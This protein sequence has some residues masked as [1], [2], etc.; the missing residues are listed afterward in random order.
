M[1]RNYLITALRHF[2]RQ[3]IYSVVNVLGLAMSTAFCFLAFL[4]VQH[5]WS[6][7][8]FHKHA[9]QIYRLISFRKADTGDMHML[10]ILPENLGPLLKGEFPQLDRIVRIVK[11]E[12]VVI[13]TGERRYREDVLFVDEDFFEL[14]SFPL[15]QGNTETFR[16]DPQSLVLSESVA[17]NLFPGENPIGKEI[18]IASHHWKNEPKTLTVGGVALDPPS[19]SSIHFR[20]LLPYKLIPPRVSGM[21]DSPMNDPSKLNFFLPRDYIFVRLHARANLENIN[22]ALPAFTKT[23]RIPGREVLL[24]FQPLTDVHLDQRPTFLPLMPSGNPVYAYILSAIA[25]MV[26]LIAS[27]NFMNLATAR[28]STRAREVGIRKVVGAQRTHL[29]WQFWGES[30]VM[31]AIAMILGISLAE[32]CL[33]T[34][35]SLI[36]VRLLMTDMFTLSFVLFAFVLMVF[37]A[38]ISGLYP[39]VNLSGFQAVTVLKDKIRSGSSGP[40]LRALIIVQFVGSILLVT[41]TAV[42]FLQVSFIKTKDLGIDRDQIAVISTD[43]LLNQ[44]NMK[45]ENLRHLFETFQQQ[46]DSYSDILGVTRSDLFSDI[47]SDYQFSKL[48]VRSPEGDEFHIPYIDIEENFLQVL[49]IELLHGQP[50]SDHTIINSQHSVL[51]NETLVKQLG[52]SQPLGYQVPLTRRIAIRTDTNQIKFRIIRNPEIA[53]IVSDFHV[54]SLHQAVPPLIIFLRPE[55]QTGEFLVRIRSERMPETLDFMARQWK[56]VFGI[57]PFNYTFLNERFDHLYQQ[58]ERW[59][60]M[61]AY[62]S[63]FALVVACLGVFGLTAMAISM[64]T[65]EF[66]IRKVFGASTKHIVTLLSMDFILLITIAT[67]IAWPL[68]YY[69]ASQWLQNFAYRIN[70]GFEIFFFGGAMTIVI[71]LATILILTIKV[72]RCN[73][74]EILRYE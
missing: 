7:D 17:Q 57:T 42:M 28:F 44:S 55:V 2:T 48:S 60:L 33:P 69:V 39:A 25:G 16:T 67:L 32:L 24:Q 74:V 52:L 36:Q 29:M 27:V 38:L 12:K 34:F 66:G 61:V 22:N 35:N 21:P 18:V 71:V 15:S 64:R 65:K 63:I 3:K 43:D 54:Q 40:I 46:L 5:E 1:L 6:Y 8:Q 11:N 45:G 4:Y 9:D 23:H 56:R 13:R 47:D 49:G 68:A 30:I 62:A 31:T 50:F 70:L 59:S 37:I 51:A 58:E 10:T 53:G 14:F 26:L 19:N 20:I 73:P 72:A 41:V